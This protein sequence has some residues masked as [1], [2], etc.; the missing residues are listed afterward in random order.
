MKSECEGLQGLHVRRAG[1]KLG[2]VAPFVAIE[3]LSHHLQAE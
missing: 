1:E 2:D 3:S